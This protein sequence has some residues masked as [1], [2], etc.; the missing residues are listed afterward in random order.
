MR[1][2]GA[3]SCRVLLF[4]RSPLI[5]DDALASVDKAIEMKGDVAKMHEARASLLRDLGRDEDAHAADARA[6]ELAAK[7]D[8]SGSNVPAA[9]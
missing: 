9:N 2:I 7:V 5:A 8:G 4:S 3:N 1:Y 6:A